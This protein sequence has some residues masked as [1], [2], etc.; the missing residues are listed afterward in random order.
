MQ[1]SEIIGNLIGFSHE[2]H[3][4]I[5]YPY[6]FEKN[7]FVILYVYNACE[8]ITFIYLVIPTLHH[9]YALSGHFM[10]YTQCL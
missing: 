8:V 6:L 7:T 1:N 2:K 9:K 10:T 5:C 3:V 4:N